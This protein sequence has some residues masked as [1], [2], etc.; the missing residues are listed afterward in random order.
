MGGRAWRRVRRPRPREAADGKD[1]VFACVGNDD[2][3]R[4]VTIGPAGCF[5]SMAKGSVFIDNTTASAEVARELAEEA[6]ARGFG[7]A[8]RAGVRRPGGR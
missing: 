8:R 4:S 7:V 6:E 2:D 1:F 5:Q 3:L